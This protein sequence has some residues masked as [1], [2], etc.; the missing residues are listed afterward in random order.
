[1]PRTDAT[2]KNG[3]FLR[4]FPSGLRVAAKS[5]FI[6]PRSGDDD[7]STSFRLLYS[8]LVPAPDGFL[9]SN[10]NRWSPHTL[11]HCLPLLKIPGNPIRHRAKERHPD[12]VSREGETWRADPVKKG[13][14][15]ET[16]GFSGPSD[17]WIHC[18]TCR[19]LSHNR[20]RPTR[21]LTEK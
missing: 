19:H 7:A 21:A 13:S 12:F 1:M 9:L 16:E 6:L 20:P 17:S 10:R 8:R 18:R 4:R 11:L 5:R 14:W 3:H 2:R 15:S